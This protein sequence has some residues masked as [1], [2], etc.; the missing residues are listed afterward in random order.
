[1]SYVH[2]HRQDQGNNRV[3]RVDRHG[4]IFTFAAGS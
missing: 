3:R 2:R 1:M 4:V